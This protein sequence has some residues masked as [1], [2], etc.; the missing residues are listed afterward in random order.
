MKE[1]RRIVLLI[2]NLYLKYYLKYL[3]VRIYRF[4]VV[5]R[6][7]LGFNPSSLK[8]KKCETLT[9]SHFSSSEDRT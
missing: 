6:S 9:E 4:R 3:D 5:N 7:S 2:L 1:T 8:I